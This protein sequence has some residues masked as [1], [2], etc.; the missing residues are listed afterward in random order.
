MGEDV[1]L[2]TKNEVRA[3]KK[4][5][6]DQYMDPVKNIQK[7]VVDMKGQKQEVRRIKD[8]IFH[9]TEGK[10]MLQRMEEERKNIASSIAGLSL[11]DKV[12]ET[13]DFTGTG[14]K[15]LKNIAAECGVEESVVEGLF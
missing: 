5:Y 7:L 8:E 4:T 3:C 12:K 14:N 9:I 2:F 1:P 11:L 10:N 6:T 13:P 15:S